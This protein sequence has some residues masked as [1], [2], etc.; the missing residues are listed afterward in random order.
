MSGFLNLEIPRDI[1]D[2]ARLTPAE[3]KLELAIALFAAERLSMGKAAELAGLS[4]SEFQ[5][6]LGARH[7]GPHYDVADALE[8]RETLAALR[9]A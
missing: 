5:L 1:L 7:I 9:D 8:D 6:Q 4:A 3:A 2:S